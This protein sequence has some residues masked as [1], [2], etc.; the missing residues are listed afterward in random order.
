M[1]GPLPAGR[2]RTFPACGFFSAPGPAAVVV[3]CAVL[4]LPGPFDLW[5]TRSPDWPSTLPNFASPD[6]PGSTSVLAVH[7]FTTGLVGHTVVY[8]CRFGY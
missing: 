6:I 8:C 4:C 3:R 1:A 2:G 7:Q 5:T